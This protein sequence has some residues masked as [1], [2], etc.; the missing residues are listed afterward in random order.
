[1]SAN[2]T[3]TQTTNSQMTDSDE[4][5]TARE[6]IAEAIDGDADPDTVAKRALGEVAAHNAT[7][8]APG[9]HTFEAAE[10]LENVLGA[11]V[12][13]KAFFIKQA[14][15]LLDREMGRDTTD[16]SEPPECV[17]W[18][19]DDTAVLKVEVTRPFVEW[20]ELEANE[21]DHDTL[22]DWVRTQLRVDLGKDLCDRHGHEANVD[23]DLPED[24][25]QRVALFYNHLEAVGANPSLGD[26]LPNHMKLNYTW[27]LNGEP[28]EFAEAVGE[29]PP[30][31][32]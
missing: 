3:T 18:R 23:I 26:I 28:W 14:A 15:S 6:A 19:D 21:T 5:T 29:N 7:R 24:Y 16:E 9:V 4:L 22:A 32:D 1:M 11:D 30:R 2:D 27:R 20:M 12:D 25:A 8:D 31:D 10:Q 17:E 13:E